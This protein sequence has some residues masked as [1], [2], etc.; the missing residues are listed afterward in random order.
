MH[1]HSFRDNS[2]FAGR[3]V[4]VVGMGNSAMDIAVE[5][6]WVAERTLLSSRSGS[7]I[8]P[9]YLFG[10]TADTITSP[11]I[12]RVVPWQVRQ[13]LS[14]LLL[15]VAVGPVESYGLGRPTRGLLEDHPTISDTILTR[16]THGEVVPKPGIAELAGDGVRFGDG[17]VERV[18]VIVWCTGYQVTLPFFE[19]G[20]LDAPPDQMLLYKRVFHPELDSL[21]FVG[22]VQST[23]SAI[24]IVEQQG[25]LVAAHLAGRYALPE[26]AEQRAEVVRARAHAVRRYGQLKRPAMRIEFDEYMHEIQREARKGERRARRRGWQRPLRRRA[27]APADAPAQ[28]APAS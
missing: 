15:R 8:V 26:P 24:P 21:F 27:S 3:R 9:K 14:H 1:S 11:F 22:L 7:R 13:P 25:R 28:P 20:L 5:S 17:S 19:P 18:D 16:I 6:S 2:G 12:A 10:R 4:L 23:G